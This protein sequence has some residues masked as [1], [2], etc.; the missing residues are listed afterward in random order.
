MVKIKNLVKLD[1]KKIKYFY[2]KKLFLEIVEI[3]K[4]DLYKII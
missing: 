2:L 1:L 3:L 4:N